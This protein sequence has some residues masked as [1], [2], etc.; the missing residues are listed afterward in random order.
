[1]K[2]IIDAEHATQE[3]VFGIRNIPLFSRHFDEGVFLL[4]YWFNGTLV[5]D[6]LFICVNGHKLELYFT[7]C[8]VSED[9]V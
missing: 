4:P 7:C 1:M 8:W 2:F 9:W 3:F 5:L 6:F